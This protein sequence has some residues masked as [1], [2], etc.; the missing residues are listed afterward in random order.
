[1]K[2]AFFLF[3]LIV[4]FSACDHV[5]K[6]GF[7]AEGDTL[8][9]KYAEMLTIVQH[10][11]YTEVNIKDPWN[12]GKILHTYFLLPDSV[13][14]PPHL[15]RG[16][17][18]RVPIKRSVLFN[19]AHCHLLYDLHAEKAISG[20]CDAEYIL[21]PDVQ[22]RLKGQQ[23]KIVDCGDGMAPM[24]EKMVEVRPQAILLSPFENSGGY[25]RLEEINIPIIECVD[26]MET[27]ALG[28]AEWMR[29]YG[30][31]FGC[32]RQAD[33]L[34]H[35]VDSCYHALMKVAESSNTHLSILTERKTGSVWYCPGGRSTLGQLIAD[36]K[37]GYAFS[38]DQHSGSLPLS[39]EQ[40]LDKAG[41]T[42]VW[43]FKYHGDRPM[44]RR[45]LLEEFHGYTGLKAFRHGMIYE[46]NCSKVPYFDEIPFR[47]DYL[48]REFIILL[49]PDITHLGKLRYYQKIPQ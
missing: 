28:R 7:S 11:A 32:E 38:D 48:L 34:F 40:V 5:R 12:Q 24:V 17:V 14:E 31:L 18:V 45:D 13:P 29:F 9:L 3:I 33:S 19:T 2:K 30:M 10:D 37:G 25:G 43:A 44:S 15:S 27:S 42:D 41:N 23:P 26:Y 4:S 21:I 47:P 8:A 49:H 36:A 46:C 35:V 39:F 1:M 20:V 6:H 22:K 16:T